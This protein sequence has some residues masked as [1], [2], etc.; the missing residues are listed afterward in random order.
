VQ[1]PN[2]FD[3]HFVRDHEVKVNP[4]PCREGEFQIIRPKR[5]IIYGRVNHFIQKFLVA[6]EVLGYAEPYPEQLLGLA[7]ILMD[8]GRA[9]LTGVE[10]IIWSY[11]TMPNFHQQ[12][13]MPSKLR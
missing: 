4:Y 9:R 7:L 6:E 13:T 1:W 3:M 5:V 10:Q 2:K 8:H 12:S 11:G